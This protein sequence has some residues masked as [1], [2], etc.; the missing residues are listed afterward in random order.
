MIIRERRET[1]PEPAVRLRVRANPN[2]LMDRI[3]GPFQRMRFIPALRAYGGLRAREAIS[4]AAATLGRIGSLEVRLARSAAEVRRAQKLRYRVFYREMGAIP[5][6]GKLLAQRDVDLFDAICEHVIVLDHASPGPTGQPGLVG[7][8]RLLR[9]Q[10]AERSGG[11][12]SGGEF[13]I[14]PLLARHPDVKFLELGR[15]CVLPAYRTKRTVELLWQ[16]IWSYVLHHGLDAMIGCASLEGTDPRELALPL[17]FLN[18]FA[19]APEQWRV[20]ALPNRYVEMNRIS[21]EQVD[22]K[23]AVHALPPLLKGYLRLGAFIGEG[24]VIDYQFGTTDVLII[25]PVFAISARYKQYFD[26]AAHRN[27]A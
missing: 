16:G 13:D 9:Q 14:A 17:S 7:T 23:A 2:G 8:Y 15:S 1:T 10:I 27:S 18:H 3:R 5:D 20:R 6:P 26:P 19:P 21:R 4:P 11:F 12:Y 24:A 22:K 25:L